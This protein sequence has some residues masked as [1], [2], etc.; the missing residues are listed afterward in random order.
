[1]NNFLP[2]GKLNNKLLIKIVNDIK[3]EG[4]SPKIGED[5]ATINIRSDNNL[6]LSPPPDIISDTPSPPIKSGSIYII[7][8]FFFKKNNKF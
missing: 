2:L 7:Y 4:A 3:N 1:M 5:S 8:I 6:L